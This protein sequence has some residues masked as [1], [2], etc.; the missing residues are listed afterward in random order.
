MTPRRQ[1][2]L[3]IAAAVIGLGVFLAANAHLAI[4]AY[5]SQPPCTAADET[6]PM[7]AKPVC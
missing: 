2:R 4:V 5:Q 1:K 7:P 3:A 6:A